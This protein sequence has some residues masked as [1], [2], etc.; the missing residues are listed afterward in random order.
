MFVKPAD[1]ALLVPVPEAPAHERWLPADG[2]EVPDTEYW[3]RR[4]A[5]GD[6]VAASRPTEPP[7][8][9]AKRTKE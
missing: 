2:A 6:V 3:R 8:A 4:L 9:P 5:Q 7:A 1:P